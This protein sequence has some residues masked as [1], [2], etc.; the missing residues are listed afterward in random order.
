MKLILAPESF[1][2]VRAY[3]E[4]LGTVFAAPNL[5]HNIL[6]KLSVSC[7]MLNLKDAC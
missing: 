6:L 7:L 2:N 5:W 4:E 3:G 1:N